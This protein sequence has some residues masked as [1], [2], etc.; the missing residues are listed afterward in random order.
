MRQRSILEGASKTYPLP[1]RMSAPD[2]SDRAAFF[3]TDRA[4]PRV[5]ATNTIMILECH[6]EIASGGSHCAGR[7]PFSLSRT[8][9]IYGECVVRDAVPVLVLLQYSTKI[10]SQRNGEY[11]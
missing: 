11:V 6:N 7:K 8:P 1:A 3:A 2:E 10:Q 4:P 9:I 5:A